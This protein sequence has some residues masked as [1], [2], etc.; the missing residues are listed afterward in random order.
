MKKIIILVLILS[1][2]TL[3]PIAR[4][5]GNCD[6]NKIP[7]DCQSPMQCLIDDSSSIFS[8]QLPPGFKTTS[9]EQNILDQALGKINPPIQV[10]NLGPGATGIS[11]VLNN[12]IQIIYVI[13]G[14]IFIFMVVFSALQWIMSGGDKEKVGAARAR[15][16]YAIIGIV[17]LALAFVLIKIVGQITGFTF[18][19]G[20][21]TSNP[22]NPLSLIQ[23]GGVCG[24][25]DEQGQRSYTNLDGTT[26][27]QER[28]NTP[29]KCSP[30][31]T[32]LPT[33]LT[34]Q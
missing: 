22:G 19:V 20:Q 28:C 11:N 13:A 6:P 33:T 34:C 1:F 26:A 9:T 24:N 30:S 5:A 21:N 32:T 2:L 15:L 29:Y 16:T 12:A 4:A 27:S 25:I 18:F 3:V 31:S 10:R 14:I 8:C 17:V 7:S 23:R